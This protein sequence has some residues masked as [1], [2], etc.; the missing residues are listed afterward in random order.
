MRYAQCALNI[1]SKFAQE[2]PE[3]GISMVPASICYSWGTE[4]STLPNG[5]KDAKESRAAGR[6]RLG[7]GSLE[8]PPGTLRERN[9]WTW[10]VLDILKLTGSI[11]LEN[12]FTH[13]SQG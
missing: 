2:N 1:L 5:C 4:V 3:A 8:R 7:S 9:A 11:G 10:Q 13:G 12:L 6:E